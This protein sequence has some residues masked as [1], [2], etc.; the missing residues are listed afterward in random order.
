M[1]VAALLALFFES[2]VTE[3][4]AC[5]PATE[6]GVAGVPWVSIVTAPHD[7][8]KHEDTSK[9]FAH[10][11]DFEGVNPITQ[12]I[13][14]ARYPHHRGL[15]L[16][17]QDTLVGGTDYDSWHMTNCYQTCTGT[18]EVPGQYTAGASAAAGIRVEWRSLT[19][20]AFLT[21]NRYYVLRSVPEGP[22]LRVCDHVS[23]LRAL[24]APIQLKGDLQ[25]AGMQIRLHGDLAEKESAAYVL[26]AGAVEGKD[27]AVSG[28]WWACCTAEILGK[29]YWVLHMTPPNHPGG[30]PVYSIRRY[31]R[32]GAFSEPTIEEGKALALSYRIVWSDAPLDQAVC[33][34]LYDAY[35]AEFTGT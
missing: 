7:G 10:L 29:R 27:D 19:G 4:V 8:T 15:F 34:A 26:P 18:I 22:S 11:L 20:E 14:G 23:E 30:Q 33:Q 5:T 12:G 21:E 16:G 9:V 25:H 31:G 28:G 24:N 3:I 2:A 1:L 32:F 6:L 13:G 17:W 35:A